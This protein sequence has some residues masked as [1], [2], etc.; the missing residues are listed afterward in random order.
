MCSLITYNMGG[1]VTQA[2]MLEFTEIMI[3]LILHALIFNYYCGNKT[4]P[5]SLQTN[6]ISCFIFKKKTL[7]FN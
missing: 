3:Y 1:L 6:I 4:L 5:E 7:G 2:A